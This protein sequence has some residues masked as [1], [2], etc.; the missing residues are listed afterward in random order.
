MKKVAK[1]LCVAILTPILLFLILTI[2]FYLPPVQN[3]VA[4]KVAAIAS[5]K[6]GMEISVG[7]VRLEWPLDLGIDDFLMLNMWNDTV[8]YTGHLTVDVQ[9]LPLF[10]K[11]VVINEVHLQHAVFDTYE[12]ISDMEISGRVGELWLRSNGIDLDKETVEVNGAR[13]QDADLDIALSDTAAVDTTSSNMRWRIN[14]DSLSIYHSAIALHLPGDTLGVS[15]YMGHVVAR[16]A[17]IDLGT[18]TYRV[19]SF[20]W[21]D[22]RLTYDNR[23]QQPVEGFDYS[24]ISLSNI[25][26]GIDSIYNGPQG[27]SLFIRETTLNE[28]SGLAVTALRGSLRLDTTFNHVDVPH[29]TLRTPDSDIEAEANVDFNITDSLN[30]GKMR[31]RLN[32]QIGKQDLIRF[33][34]GL[35]QQFIRQYP[36]HPIS[37]KGSINGNTSRMEFTG[38]DVQ[39]PTALHLK[40]DGFAANV[41]DINRLRGQIALKAETHDLTFLTTLTD[42]KGLRLPPMTL[43]GTATADRAR[44]DL[45]ALLREGKGTVKADI[46]TPRLTDI[47]AYTANVSVDRLNLR[48]FLSGDA[49]YGYTADM[50]ADA[51]L[52]DGH[53]LVSVSGNNAL[54]DGNIVI[55]ARLDTKR[56]EA[57]LKPQLARADL[58]G[59]KLTDEPLT[60]GMYGDITLKSDLKQSHE[61]KGR[62]SAL[63]MTDDK[64]TYH[65]EDIVLLVRTSRDTTMERIQS[66]DFIVKLDA[67]TD[68]E[69]LLK[70][71]TTL[72]DSAMAQYHDK[73]IDQSAIKRLLPTMK[74]HVESRRNNPLA[75][76]LRT[77]DIDF[78]E[79]FADVTTSP[80]TG[81]NGQM[82]LYSLNYDSTRIDTIRLALTQR[83]DRLTYQ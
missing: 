12:A 82:H 37:I 76:I 79:L 62:L 83:G 48:H 29:L 58:F 11:R 73:V 18:S 9:L 17:D 6:T 68:Y 42:V 78:K 67:N 26:V 10:N 75:N 7:T 34:G 8:A 38:L 80:V 27:T 44:Y 13:L 61:L 32:A 4:D 43:S 69:R 77:R 24:H 65:P 63:Y 59:L 31:V 35:P 39:L 25:H 54:F 52:K 5:E 28:K 66:G 33:A 64:A 53:A 71:G 70:Q 21:R 36:N 20:D 51:T 22:G 1:W 19:G 49:R 72:L 56:V 30:P 46:H 81:I 15:A 55:D 47:T 41:T 45:K 60:I 50:T 74:L 16:D 23:H 3:W 57:T 40:A 14:A 2:L